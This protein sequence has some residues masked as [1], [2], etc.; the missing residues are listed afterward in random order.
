MDF[1]NQKEIFVWFENV[2]IR[3]Y[4]I[5]DFHEMDIFILVY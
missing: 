2:V 5:Y 1:F 3:S 4:K